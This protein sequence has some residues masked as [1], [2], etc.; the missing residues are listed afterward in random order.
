MERW[1]RNVI[2]LGGRLVFMREGDPS[3]VEYHAAKT[4][5][6]TA[7]SQPLPRCAPEEAGVSPEVIYR[8]LCALAA[9]ERFNLHNLVIIKNG[10]IILEISRTGYDIGLWCLSHSLSKTLVG[11][12]I[13]MLCDDG[14]L[15]LDARICEIFPRLRIRDEALR[16]ATVEHL[17][18][19]RSG[20][21]FAEV[22]V[23]AEDDWLHAFF[24]SSLSAKPGT[25]FAYNS[26][27][28]YVLGCIARKV[29]GLS[30]TDMLRPR[31]LEPLGV[32][33]FLWETCHKGREKGG[34][35]AYMCLEDWCKVGLLFCRGG[36]WK[37]TQILSQR[38]VESATR[39]KIPTPHDTGDYDYGYHIWLG[40]ENGNI[41]LSGMFGQNIWVCP[42][43]DII[44][45]INAGNNELFQN[46]PGLRLIEQHLGGELPPV[47][48]KYA[49]RLVGIGERYFARTTHQPPV[50]KRSVL[51]KLLNLGDLPR[52]WESIC[53][54]YDFAPNNH[55]IFPL[56]I[57][58]MQNNYG[59]GIRSLMLEK[60]GGI[61]TAIFVEEKMQLALPIGFSEPRRTVIDARGEKYLVLTR[62]N[63]AQDEG[64]C[65]M[66][67]LE[68]TFPETPN[69]RTI[70]IVISNN[71]EVRMEL[72]EMPNRHALTSMLAELSHSNAVFAMIRRTLEHRL[73]EDLIERKLDEYFSPTLVGAKRGCAEYTDIIRREAEHTAT[74]PQAARIAELL[75]DRPGRRI[76]AL[77]DTFDSILSALRSHLPRLPRRGTTE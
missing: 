11:A 73:G 35:G 50:K 21:R 64:G 60:I 47:S 31:L 48:N 19:M 8:M 28:S 56:F 9:E 16:T 53:G 10:H 2:E 7:R 41:L 20:V 39:V 24:S 58:L 54:T 70:S 51:S 45:G 40:R 23:V 27:N 65:R 22:G 75:I 36:R 6:P 42:K 26:M 57:R 59:G 44:V 71:G 55:G 4:E 37:N 63:L 1:L 32:G 74:D 33:S 43:N 29:S 38:W 69:T 12:A 68:L 5:L 14:E 66:L 49:P 13:G 62:G 52:G 17:L 76:F 77:G 67:K 30:L 46:S 72:S 3:V 25:R 18:T 61:A 15:S 34:L